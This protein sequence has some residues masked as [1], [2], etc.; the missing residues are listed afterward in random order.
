MEETRLELMD[1]LP[2]ILPQLKLPVDSR[3]HK[4]LRAYLDDES[5]T[6]RLQAP[7]GNR[8]D[9]LSSLKQRLW[10]ELTDP[11]IC[12]E[13]LTAIRAKIGDLGYSPERVLFELFQ[14]ADDAYGQMDHEVDAASFR[15]EALGSPD[16]GFRTAPRGWIGSPSAASPAAGTDP[17]WRPR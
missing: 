7:G 15:V 8:A 6:N 5:Q 9:K 11:V 3:A 12:Q 4:V 16:G 10:D 13:L 2:S 1:R 17:C 14:N